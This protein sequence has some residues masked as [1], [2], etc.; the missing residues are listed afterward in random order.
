MTNA[1]GVECNQAWS[2]ADVPRAWGAFLEGW[3]W[4]WFTTN[5]FRN[6]THPEAAGKT[7]NR[8]IHQLNRHIFGV[9]YTKRLHDGVIWARGL[10][11]QRRGVI[12][13]HALIGRVPA[14]VRRLDWMDVWDGLAGYA[15]IEPYDPTRG[16]R[17]YLGKYVLKGG[18]VDL[19]GPLR[20][21]A[22]LFDLRPGSNDSRAEEG[23]PE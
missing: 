4:S 8:W 11:Y 20:V 19:G 22:P 1:S 12:H 15:R 16:A 5:T 18:E 23:V 3:H 21:L 9:R 6:D 17:Y 10:E 2:T 13:F 7:W 14:T